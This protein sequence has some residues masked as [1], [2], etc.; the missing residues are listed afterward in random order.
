MGMGCY[1]ILRQFQ[2]TQTRRNFCSRSIFVTFCLTERGNMTK[3]AGIRQQS[4][5]NKQVGISKPMREEGQNLIFST[6]MHHHR[7]WSAPCAAN[8]FHPIPQHHHSPQL[9]QVHINSRF[10]EE[11]Q[12]SNSNSNQPLASS[13]NPKNCW[14]KLGLILHNQLKHVQQEFPKAM[15]V[16]GT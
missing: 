7:L 10:E 8:I 13:P 12:I 3:L 15:R 4:T 9:R 11:F 6:P 16:A 1:S 2:G 14:P 5:P